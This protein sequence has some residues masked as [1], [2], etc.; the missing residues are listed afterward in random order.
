MKEQHEEFFQNFF[1]KYLVV[2]KKGSTFALAI[3][4]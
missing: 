3:K 4:K 2:S 1:E